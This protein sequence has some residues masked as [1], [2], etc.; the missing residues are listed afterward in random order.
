LREEC[1]LRVFENKALR[2]IFGPKR[3]EVTGEW[4]RLHNIE[5]YALYSLN[6]IRVIKSRRLGWAGHV[7]RM[8]E[9]RGA[10]RASVGK[11]EGRRPLGRPR[12]RWEDNIKMDLREVGCGGV[13]WID[14]AQDRNRW[15]ALVY[16]VMNLRVP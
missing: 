6:I 5:H 8:G 3:D 10:Y 1:R 15:R 13:D 14:L 2:R 16:T 9:R 4:R 12:L 11:P 7:A